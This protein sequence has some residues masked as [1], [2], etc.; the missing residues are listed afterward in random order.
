MAAILKFLPKEGPV[1]DA[2]V[3]AIMGQAFDFVIAQ[4]HDTGQPDLV[5]EIIAKQIVEIAARGE[6]NP[7]RMAD[8]ALETLGLRRKA[9]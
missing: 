1:F 6:R 4:L 8:I 2:D 5:Q 7:A 9:M 3:T